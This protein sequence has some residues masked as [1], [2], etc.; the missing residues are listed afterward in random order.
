LHKYKTQGKAMKKLLIIN[1]HQFYQG[2]AEGKLAKALIDTTVDTLGN[3]GFEIKH[4]VIESGYDIQEEL[5]KFAWADAV[6][7]HYPV[8]WMTVPWITKKYIDEIF[9][10]GA[11]S[12]TYESDGRSRNDASKR[13]GSGGLMK[14]KHYML[15]MTYNCPTSEFNDKEGFF[16]GLSVDEVNFAV[17]KVFQ[18]CGLKQLETYSMHDIFKG[19]R[20]ETS[21]ESFDLT[22][23]LEKFK[24][25][26][27]KN[28]LK[29]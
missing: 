8:F 23:E 5:Q 9:S 16:E 29:N 12:V 6:L 22:G 19:G 7:L 14:D 3:N 1:G 21:Q 20:Y 27:K 13:Y 11:K 17:H 26:L 28:F 10:S 24:A 2:S 25:I 18:F 15:T 4:T